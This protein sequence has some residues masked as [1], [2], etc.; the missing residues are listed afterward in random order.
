MTGHKHAVDSG[1]AKS[2][3]VSRHINQ[4]EH[5]HPWYSPYM[6]PRSSRVA[7]SPPLGFSDRITAVH[8]HCADASCEGSFQDH[9]RSD[10]ITAAGF[11]CAKRSADSFGY[12]AKPTCTR[13]VEDGRCAV[14]LC[15]GLRSG[16]PR[17]SSSLQAKKYAGLSRNCIGVR[18]LPTRGLGIKD[19]FEAHLRKAHRLHVTRKRDYAESSAGKCAK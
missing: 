13:V 17:Q 7:S 14:R 8:V 1:P 16:L 3:T 11:H 19:H 9:N 10:A 12:G 15:S 4:S 2:E 5:L 18:E 6:C